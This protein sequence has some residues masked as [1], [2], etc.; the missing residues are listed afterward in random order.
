[1]AAKPLPATSQ[2]AAPLPVGGSFGGYFHALNTQAFK[3][4]A[5]AGDCTLTIRLYPILRRRKP[6]VLFKILA[7]CGLIRKMDV[8][9]HLCDADLVI[10]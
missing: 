6:G 9:C 4:I 3:P 2:P 5:T 8:L 1:M 7:K 10:S